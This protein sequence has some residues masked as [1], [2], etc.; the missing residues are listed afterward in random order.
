MSSAVFQGVSQVQP[1]HKLQA[2][3]RSQVVQLERFTSVAGNSS[4]PQ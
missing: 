1:A 2:R 3:R 4:K